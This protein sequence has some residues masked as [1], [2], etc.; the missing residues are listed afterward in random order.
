MPIR[1]RRYLITAIVL[2]IGATLYSMWRESCTSGCQLREV[3]LGFPV[4]L[5][6]PFEP[7]S[8]GGPEFTIVPF[9][10]NVLWTIV[11]SVSFWAVVDTV[12]RWRERSRQPPIV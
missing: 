8:P 10:V 11:A 12:Q 5:R 4:F 3:V 2:F 7:Y 1:I 9:F 6:T